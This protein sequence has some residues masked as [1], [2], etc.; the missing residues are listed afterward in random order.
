MAT[1]K[2]PL[3]DT[4][5]HLVA[6][7]FEADRDDVLRRARAN[8]VGAF[9]VP[10][11]DIETSRSAVRLAEEHTDVLAA[12]GVHPHAAAEFSPSARAELREL[13]RSERVVAIGEIGLDYFRFRAP[14]QVQEAAFREQLDLAAELGLPVI[15]HHRQSLPRVF[16][17]VGQWSAQAGEADGRRGVLHAYSGDAASAK[18]AIAAGF[19]LGVAGP[20]TFP[21]AKDRRAVTA[22]LPLDRLVLET[23]APYLAPQP[24]RGRRNEPSYLPE[25]AGEL[26][27][28]L[29]TTSDQVRA[30]TTRNARTLF[31][32]RH[33]THHRDLL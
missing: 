30:Q 31:S 3:I 32:G 22:Q 13:A 5:C 19:Y 24:H 11:V 1:T 7:E 28:V 15:I 18:Q 21:N 14:V 2:S 25:I 8:G 27:R 23:D 9:V 26:A 6:Q 17:L 29:E 12:V 16:E 20:I 10:G 4:H 33:G